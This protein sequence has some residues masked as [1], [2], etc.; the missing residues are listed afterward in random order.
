MN[1][2]KPCPF[3]GGEVHRIGGDDEDTHDIECNNS[4][5]YIFYDVSVGNDWWNT[6]PI[7]DELRARI[8]NLYTE[9]ADASGYVDDGEETLVNFVRNMRTEIERLNVELNRH[10]GSHGS[11]RLDESLAD[12]IKDQQE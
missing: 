9:I 1:E 3:C 4:C 7:E 6:R 5:A 2:L 12:M 10:R 8:D 11:I